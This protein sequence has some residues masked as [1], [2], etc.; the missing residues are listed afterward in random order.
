[1]TDW[2]EALAYWHWWL[3]AV[4]LLLLEMLAPGVFFLWMGLAAGV[5]GL[6]LFLLP[7]LAW[8]WQLLAFAVGSVCF[9]VIARAWLR[10]H[11]I[12][13]DQP[14]LNRRGEQYVDRV[15]TLDAPMVN[16]V[17]KLS[18]DDTTWKIHGPD[19]AAGT[20]VKVTGVEGVVLQ[21]EC[22]DDRG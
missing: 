11:P 20:R 19:C 7:S 10:R 12:E 8:E 5:V 15:F 2:L 9:A 17:G 22:L 21:V 16:G 1:M 13:T 3:L 18:V 14:R 4:A 6:L